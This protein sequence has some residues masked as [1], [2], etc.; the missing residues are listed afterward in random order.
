MKVDSETGSIMVS[1][2]KPIGV[3]TI[4]IIGTL[5][6]LVTKNSAIFNIYV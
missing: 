2:L 4:E 6:D 1:L 3:Y 5:P